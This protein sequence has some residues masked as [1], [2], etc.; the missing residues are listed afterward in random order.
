MQDQGPDLNRPIN[1]RGFLEAGTGALAVA[2]TLGET[3][4]AS[5][6]RCSQADRISRAAQADRWAEPASM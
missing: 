3:T 2:A 6:A 1:R 4:C 5:R